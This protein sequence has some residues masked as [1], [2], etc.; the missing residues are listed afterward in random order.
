M[1]N[2]VRDVC[3]NE[4]E[5]CKRVVQIGLEEKNT[6]LIIH[7]IEQIQPR[8]KS[9]LPEVTFEFDVNK[10]PFPQALSIFAEVSKGKITPDTG[11]LLIETLAMT[12]QIEEGSELRDQFKDMLA[13]I[14]ELK[15]QSET[16]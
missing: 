14:D 1:L 8:K 7:A 9:T 11:K 12:L 15:A 3:G 13:M 2:A 6:T 10:P 5:Y 16:N 4:S